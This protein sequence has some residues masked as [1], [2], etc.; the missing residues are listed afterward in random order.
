MKEEAEGKV[1]A[2]AEAKIRA[3]REAA[4]RAAAEAKAKADAEAKAKV[5][6]ERRAREEMERRLEQERKAREEAERKAKEEAERAERVRQEAEEQAR[7]VREEVERKAKEEAE[8]VRKE[9]EAERKR[10]EEDKKRHEEERRQE[11]ERA[12]AKRKQREEEEAERE[13]QEEAERAEKKRKREEAELQ[14]AAEAA[15]A[16]PKPEEPKEPAKP[17]SFSDSLLA[18]LESFTKKDDEEQKAQ[19]AAERKSKSDAERRKR[20]EA[21]RQA[22]EQAEA[23]QR[24][25]EQA[26]R[27]EEE[28]RKAREEEERIAREEER[29]QREAEEI[30]RKA[31]AA[32]AAAMAKQGAT[33]KEEDIPISD[34]DLDM[35]DVKKD[36]KALGISE[37]KERETRREAE[38][39]KREEDKK[40]REAETKAA[41]AATAA[42]SGRPRRPSNWGRP[43]AIILVLVLLVAVAAAHFVPLSTTEYER[44]ATE[45]LG[46]PVKIGSAR[47]WLFTGVQVRLDDVHIGEARIA[48]VITHPALGSVFS[49]Q[50]HFNA[51]E[52]EGLTLPQESLGQALFTKVK[53]DNFS[54]ERIQAHQLELPG[55]LVLPKKLDADIVLDAEGA[56]RSGTVRGPDGLV[57]RLAPKGSSI[58]FDVTAAGFTLPIA[59]QVTLSQFGMKGSATRGGMNIAEWGGTIFNGGISGTAN[60]RWGGTWQVDGVLT[61][62]GINAA[63]FAPALLSEG[64]AEGTGK[65][66]MSGVEPA[67]LLA[68]GRV[69][70]NFTVSK[71]VLGSFDLSRAIQSRGKTVTGRTQFAEMSGQAIYDRG[72]VALRNVTIGA[73]ALNAGASADIAQSGALSGRIIADVRNAGQTLSAT[74]LLGGTVKEPQVRN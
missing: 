66:S 36:R 57:A 24:E 17:E 60:L 63:V 20:E 23:Q 3:V 58:E 43:V 72:A 31:E 34:D 64:K 18:D 59:P 15:V 29:R 8:R 16:K 49:D 35:E 22:Q 61:V 19:E 70:G 21:E 14:A 32:T 56:L 54:V 62:R 74:L 4:V 68:D 38:K 1:K 41:R 51:V 50:K 53:G 55:A 39:R 5:D 42:P 45:A 52:L 6:A 12:A 28:K 65:F 13:R 46:Q 9:L 27:K 30:K 71:G 25:E 2:E 73:G 47:L 26:R 33:A 11:E 10:L 48:R 69:E 44:G 67:K 37:K 7:K 40:R